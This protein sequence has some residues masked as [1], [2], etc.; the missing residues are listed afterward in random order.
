MTFKNGSIIDNYAIYGGGICIY[1]GGTATM[2]GG[3]IGNNSGSS[4]GGGV[5]VSNGTFRKASVSPDG[6]S[7]IIYGASAGEGLANTGGTAS[8]I[9]G[10]PNRND[11]L[12]QYDEY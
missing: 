4:Y 6:M 8:A 9:Y 5:Y 1:S 3:I 10:S 7:G 12:G 11:T 2:N